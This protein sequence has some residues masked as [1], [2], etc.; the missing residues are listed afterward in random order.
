MLEIKLN[1][2]DA[3]LSG[4]GSST[5]KMSEVISKYRLEFDNYAIMKDAFA[6]CKFNPTCAKYVNEKDSEILNYLYFDAYNKIENQAMSNKEWEQAHVDAA[7]IQEVYQ[8]RETMD[9]E[10]F[11]Y[12][13]KYYI[14]LLP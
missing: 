13:N 9:K 14:E 1:L 6:N 10:W 3:V 4:S 12:L 7:K 8:N 5:A 2:S 11:D